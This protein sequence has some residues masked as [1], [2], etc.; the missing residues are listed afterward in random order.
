MTESSQLSFHKI[1]CFII[2]LFVWCALTFPVWPADPVNMRFGHMRFMGKARSLAE[3]R[4]NKITRQGWD[5]SCGAAALSTLLTYHHEKQFSE[6]AITLSI[7]KN[8]DPNRVRARGGFSLYDLK[9]FV[10]AVGL[11]GLGFADMSIEDLSFYDIPAILP[12][13]MGDLDHFV[14]FKKRLGNHILF[15]DPAFGNISLRADRFEKI[16][17]SRIAF[18]VVTPEEKSYLINQRKNYKKTPLS[19]EPMEVSIPVPDYV[20]RIINRMPTIP[21]TKKTM[22]VVPIQ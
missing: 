21:L 19:P 7:L 11:E 20:G 6:I 22:T 15:G 10:Q 8:V 9:R 2:F 17:K 12:T 18:Y 14:V 1:W 4:W 16:W 13:R 3:I 5:V